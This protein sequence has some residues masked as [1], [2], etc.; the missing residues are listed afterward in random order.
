MFPKVP[1]LSPLVEYLGAAGSHTAELRRLLWSSK[2]K[3]AADKNERDSVSQDEGEGG[4]SSAR[5]AVS[6]CGGLRHDAVECCG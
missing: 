2:S 6:E 3:A 4:A 5:K 1:N